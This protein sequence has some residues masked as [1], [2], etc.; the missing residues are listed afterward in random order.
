MKVYIS[1]GISKVFDYREVFKEAENK[2]KLKGHAVLN[3]A[4]FDA[5]FSQDD[6]MH[7]SYAMI[8]CC[9]VIYM[10][11]NHE[12]SKGA[13]LELEYAKGKSKKIIYEQ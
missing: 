4:V 12:D 9:D 10:L 8:D 3:P 13:A 11:K 6:Y 5:G 1:G 2:L 7:I